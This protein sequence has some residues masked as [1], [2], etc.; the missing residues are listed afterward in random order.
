MED[1]SLAVITLRP[2]YY[3]RSTNSLTASAFVV[4]AKVLD[5]FYVNNWSKG[6][7]RSCRLESLSHKVAAIHFI[8]FFL[9]LFV[10]AIVAIH[11]SNFLFPP[12]PRGSLFLCYLDIGPKSFCIEQSLM[13]TEWHSN[14]CIVTLAYVRNFLSRLSLC[15]E[16]WNKEW[17]ESLVLST[18]T[19][20][21]KALF[22][23]RET[24]MPSA[25]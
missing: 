17:V 23:E 10:K 12:T 14:H 25:H 15:T 4:Y 13:T 1:K 7:A 19:L 11:S 22:A 21:T 9:V 16:C 3:C 5:R 2:C 24:F 20:V 6:S 18:R 8:F